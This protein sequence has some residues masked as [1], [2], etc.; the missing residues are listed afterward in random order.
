MKKIIAG[1]VLT[2]IIVSIWL[3]GGFSVLVLLKL[4]LPKATLRTLTGALGLVI[5][6]TG[7]WIGIKSA[8]K[9]HESERFTYFDAFKSGFIIS[10]IVAVIV[11]LASLIYVTFINPHFA[12]DMVKEAAL[13]L[14]ASGASHQQVTEHLNA[15]RNEFSRRSQI[16]NP[17]IVQTAAGTIFSLILAFFL[18][19]K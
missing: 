12:D 18:K 4:D 16:I 8:K 6:F 1:G 7:V 15:V 11:S 3:I 14:K 19:K 10:V 5:L 13:S 2:G 17:L 9:E